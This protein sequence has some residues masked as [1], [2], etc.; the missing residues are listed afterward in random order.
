M[1]P[2]SLGGFRGSSPRASTG[3]C[4][5][6]RAVSTVAA[7]A[8]SLACA[9]CPAECVITVSTCDSRALVRATSP[10]LR[11]CGSTLWAM[12]AVRGRFGRRL[13]PA[14]MARYG[15]T[16]SGVSRTKTTRSAEESLRPAASQP[17]GRYQASLRWVRG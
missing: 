3:R 10:G 7:G 16:W 11:S 8:S 5:G 15:G 14:R 6:I 2:P 13:R 17:S 9:A 12:T 1:G 4:G